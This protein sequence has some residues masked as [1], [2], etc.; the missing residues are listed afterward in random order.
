M[1][2][3]MQSPRAWLAL[4]AR[5][6]IRSRAARHEHALSIIRKNRVPIEKPKWRAPWKLKTVRRPPSRAASPSQRG[7]VPVSSAR[8]A[9]ARSCSA[10]RLTVPAA[11]AAH[12]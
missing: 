5:V 4:P 2:G 10:Q 11:V 8:F 9:V 3:R 12:R 7:A 1:T 6:A